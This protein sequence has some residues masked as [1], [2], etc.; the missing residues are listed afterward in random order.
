M[1]PQ[2]SRASSPNPT[3]NLVGSRK[4]GQRKRREAIRGV[5]HFGRNSIFSTRL[6]IQ[7]HDR[8]LSL[9]VFVVLEFSR[10][11]V[12]RRLRAADEAMS[13]GFKKRVRAD[14]ALKIGTALRSLLER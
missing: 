10:F 2:A 7:K 8:D 11:G 4:A 12:A 9:T 3:A 5:C 13:L 14:D 1:R 6:S